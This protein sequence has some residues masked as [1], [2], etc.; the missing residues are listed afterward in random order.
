M[1]WIANCITWASELIGNF[2][3]TIVLLVIASQILLVPCKMWAH[4][5]QLAKQA[6]EPELQRIRKKYNANQLGVSMDE[7]RDLDPEVRKMS[8]D[9]RDE[10]MANEID[11]LYK[12]HGYHLWTAWVPTAL[13]LVFL[14]LLWG[15]I[16]QAAPEGFF[17]Y[18]FADIQG[19]AT[20]WNLICLCAT[21]VLTF[22][23][24]CVTLIKNIIK[25]K[26]DNVPLKPIILAG[27]ISLII[28]VALS[29]WIATSITT[30][31]AIALCTLQLWS[32]VYGFIEKLVTPN[33][34]KLA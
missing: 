10:A 22:A 34:A 14:I 15:G 25:S 5:N 12:A 1:N 16:N 33:P 20:T 9:E 21:P 7:A 3:W 6:C 18:K 26:K 27:C 29:V 19:D 24:G 13:N 28:S 4:Q 11:A 31:L 17:Q 32:L 8:H 2:G 23:S 30:A